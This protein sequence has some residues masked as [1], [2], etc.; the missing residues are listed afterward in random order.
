MAGETEETCF[1]EYVAAREQ[2]EKLM[3]ELR[4]GSARGLEHGEAESLIARE[5]NELMR[6]LMQGY[7]D[8]RT[9]AEERCEGVTGAAGEERRHCRA[10]S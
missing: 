8:Q 6:R 1:D 5:G 2:F 3:G 9:A 7:V 10:R 4:S